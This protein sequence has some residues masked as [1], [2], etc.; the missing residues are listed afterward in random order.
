ML[1]KQP[2]DLFSL[3]LRPELGSSKS[4]VSANIAQTHSTTTFGTILTRLV[5]VYSMYQKVLV[6]CPVA[7]N[8]TSYRIFM[9]QILSHKF[10]G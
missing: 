3:R 9:H 5:S 1:M 10:L 7:F 2:P 8:R 4:C 6:K